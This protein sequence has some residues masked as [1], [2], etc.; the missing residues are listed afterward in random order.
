MLVILEPFLCFLEFV[1]GRFP[2]LLPRVKCSPGKQA[3]NQAAHR[4]QQANQ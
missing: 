1:L 4:T 3:N 2:L